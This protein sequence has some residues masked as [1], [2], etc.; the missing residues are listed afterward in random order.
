MSKELVYVLSPVRKATDEQKAVVDKYAELL[1]DQKFEV[2]NPRLDV[3][4]ADATGYNIVMAELDFLH[5]IALEGGR[6]DIFWNLGGKPSEGSRVDVGMAMALGLELKLVGV[7]NEKEPTGPQAAY[8][9]I[10]NS[11]EDL[12]EVSNMLRKIKRTGEVI[13]DWNT[14]MTGE[15][16]E[17]QRFKLG[18]ALGCWAQNPDIRIKLG[19]LTG[20][21]LPDEKSYPKVIRK[22]EE[23]V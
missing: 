14:E 17:W 12:L 4:Q 2:V 10:Q 8:R 15:V 3:L 20:I 13:V 5:R 16:E 23:L 1:R 9:I 11:N 7:F 21:D 19:K 6:V 18:L 22:I